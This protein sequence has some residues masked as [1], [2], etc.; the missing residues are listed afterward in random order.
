[1]A[2]FLG[3]KIKDNTD[4]NDEVIANNM[5]ASATAGAQAYLNATI[6]SATPELRAMYSASLNQMVGGHTAI[7]ELSIKKG[8]EKPYN[9]PS[10]QLSDAYSKSKNTLN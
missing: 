2:S 5:I 4:I 1:M 3:N 9:S 10:E 8:W 6:S 7:T